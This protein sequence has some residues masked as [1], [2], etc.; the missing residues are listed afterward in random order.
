M[1]KTY[2]IIYI[3]IFLFGPIIQTK[4]QVLLNEKAFSFGGI[5]DIPGSLIKDS[6]NNY[7]VGG[8][9]ERSG[10]HSYAGLIKFNSNFDSLWTVFNPVDSTLSNFY[11]IAY[12]GTDSTLFWFS[13]RAFGVDTAYIAKVSAKTGDVIFWKKAN[14]TNTT[15]GN[16]G[17]KILFA[18][19]G[20]PAIIRIINSDGSEDSNFQFSPNADGNIKL[21]TLGNYLWISG[22]SS[23]IYFV[24]KYHL[25]DGTMVWEKTYQN[26][27]SPFGTLD[28]SG[29]FYLV[30][31]EINWQ[32]FVF[33][34][35]VIKHDINGNILWKKQWV[36]WQTDAQNQ[37]NI[38]QGVAVNE[39]KNI[40][41]PFGTTNMIGVPTN[42]QKFSAYMAGLNIVTG[43]TVWT[44]IWNYP[45]Q[46]PIIS[47]VNAG[48]FDSNGNLITV[49][50]TM[51]R[52]DGAIPN[53]CYL[54]KYQI[55]KV[56][57]IEQINS[58]IPSDF[59]L[60]Q[61]YPNP[62]N[63]STRIRFS[64]AKP[65]FVTL[66]VYDLLGREVTTLVNG[67]K[68]VGS[69]EVTFNTSELTSKLSSGIYIYRLTTDK[70][71][72]TKKMIL[73]K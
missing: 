28:K 55:D 7:F 58:S 11:S 18:E 62:F 60:S 71:T 17:N 73:M 32:A 67:E 21:A 30:Y 15:L 40:V 38:F 64:V 56:T 24:G 25:P 61:N 54:S 44:K 22:Y 23:D 10:L 4:G 35:T 41:I 2:V 69:Y 48:L 31:S 72:Q 43:D 57:G 65:S 16:W 42:E 70:F 52:S 26:V 66:K 20:S 51:S 45:S 63:P 34:F 6:Q 13:R 46:L 27:I 29:N 9:T 59:V 3:F 49:G 1:K 39:E 19:G 37:N 50:N 14:S 33:T 5:N 68:S 8:Y 53:V 47:R 36:P 12:S